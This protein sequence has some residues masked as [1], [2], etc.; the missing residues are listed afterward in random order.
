[1]PL[2]TPTPKDTATNQ[3]T[4]IDNSEERESDTR[5]LCP[6]EKYKSR[7]PTRFSK[8]TDASCHVP[9]RGDA[10]LS[11]ALTTP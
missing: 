10:E 11:A 1:M 3:A 6:T 2:T 9:L 8:S 4:L 5:K 7:C